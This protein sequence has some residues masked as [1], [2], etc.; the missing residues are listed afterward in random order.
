MAA[1]RRRRPVPRR[2]LLLA[3]AALVPFGTA[4]GVAT[5]KWVADSEAAFQKG[6]L[7]RLRVSSKGTLHRGFEAKRVKSDAQQVWDSLAEDSGEVLVATGS[8][9][10]LARVKGD[11]VHTLFTVDGAIALSNLVRDGNGD[12]LASSFPDGRIWRISIQGDKA[13]GKEV[14]K[15]PDPYVWD[16]VRDKDG[17]LF[18]ATGIE[19]KEGE[20]RVWRILPDGK[21]E[22]WYKSEEAHLL[23][24][25]IAP[26]GALLAG[27]GETG[28]LYR[29]EEKDKARI[30]HDFAEEEVRALAVSGGDLWVAVNSAKGERGAGGGG[31]SPVP[32]PAA[33]AGEGGVAAAVRAA[34]RPAEGDKGKGEGG[35]GDGSALYKMTLA[36]QR[37][38]LERRF[39]EDTLQDL[40]VGEGGIAYVAAGK[41][42]KVY[43]VVDRDL[44]FLLFD[45]EEKEI[46]HVGLAQG[47]LRVVGTSQP[48]AAYLVEPEPAKSGL[49]TSDVFDAGFLSKWGGLAWEGE[50]EIAFRTRSGNTAKPDKTWSEWADVKGPSPGGVGSP[51]GRYAQFQAELKAASEPVLRSATLYYLNQNQRPRVEEVSIEPSA[52]PESG[53]GGDAKA[54]GEGATPA[55]A[56]DAGK[57]GAAAAVAA[58]APHATVRK[59]KWTA[60]DEDGDS[61]EFWVS[62][63]GEGEK[64]WVP[65]VEEKKPLSEAEYSWD[66]EAVPD[67][68]YRVKV[69]AGDRKGNPPD[70]AFSVEKESEP[71]LVDNGRPEV[72]ELAFDPAAGRVRGRAR[73]GASFV[74]A[75]S[76]LVDGAEWKPA[77]PADGIF[78]SKDEA[79]AIPLPKDLAPGPHAVAVKATDAEGNIGAGRIAIE[80]PAK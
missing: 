10:A 42:G 39:P 15:L 23:S 55:K 33:A 35:G 40:R 7:E 78:D 80:V 63:K 22:T 13:E 48:G 44:S 66:T 11:A 57:E 32:K 67:G 16:M 29:I 4:E 64:A 68:K 60:T 77:A 2:A 21:I 27:G 43:S 41:S 76:Y 72:L 25:A 54:S 65:L 18:A 17:N 38:E 6:K 61:L 3:A 45:L 26:D 51:P 56:P 73:D 34:A 69:R 31:G 30:L 5:K 1:V 74:A 9:A 19:E 49:F 8:P 79:F 70:D 53:G 37:L 20:G 75:L 50:G 28:Y 52:A 62:Y 59:I 12:V 47:R 14:A 71:F 46:L 58:P 36:D 24:L